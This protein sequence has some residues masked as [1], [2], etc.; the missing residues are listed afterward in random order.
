MECVWA[1]AL[2]WGTMGITLLVFLGL[3]QVLPRSSWGTLV[4]IFAAAAVSCYYWFR[5]PAL[6][7]YGVYPQDG[8]LFDLRHTLPYWMVLAAQ[9][10]ALTFFSWWLV[11]RNPA[12]GVWA[13]RPPFLVKR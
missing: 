5:I 3:R 2:P 10:S 11:L 1:Y 6:V 7:G 8:L 4:N 13:L 12:P 9:L